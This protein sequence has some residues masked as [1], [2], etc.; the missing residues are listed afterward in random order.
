[1]EKTFEVGRLIPS[2]GGDESGRDEYCRT[3]ETAFRV[4]SISNDRCLVCYSASITH[5]VAAIAHRIGRRSSI[6]CTKHCPRIAR[7]SASF[8]SEDRVD[9]R[10]VLFLRRARRTILGVI[11]AGIFQCRVSRG[12][13]I[14][15]RGQSLRFTMPVPKSSRRRHI[16]VAHRLSA[17]SALFA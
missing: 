16:S 1:M 10:V 4:G 11:T 8:T 14:R 5:G 3:D 13:V 6:A 17:R 15:N 7:Q 2:A 9:R 12:R